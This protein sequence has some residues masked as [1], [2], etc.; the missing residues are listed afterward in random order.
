MELADRT[1]FDLLVS[2]QNSPLIEDRIIKLLIPVCRGLKH[3]HEKGV[4]HRD[5]KVENILLT[6]HDTVPKI[7]DF[8]LQRND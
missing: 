5:I 4:T 6:S 3:M 7:C 2:S 1:L 8:G